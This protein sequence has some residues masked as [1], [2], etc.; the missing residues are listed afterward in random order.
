MKIRSKDPTFWMVMFAAVVGGIVGAWHGNG[1]VALLA[2][3]IVML[4]GETWKS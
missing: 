3:A 1:E 4:A 2:V